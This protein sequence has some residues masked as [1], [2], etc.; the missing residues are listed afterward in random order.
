MGPKRG[1]ELS[2]VDPAEL[3]KIDLEKLDQAWLAQPRLMAVFGDE[4]AR[5]HAEMMGVDAELKRTLAEIKLLYRKH[6]PSGIKITESALQELVD[7]ESS[8]R[9]LR[10]QLV[11]CTERYERLRALVFA[12]ENRKSAL[13]NLVRLYNSEYFSMPVVKIEHE[14]QKH[15][16]RNKLAEESRHDSKKKG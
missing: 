4:M 14:I 10:E 13:E 6:P 1:V 15:R 5:A 3:V 12:L 2:K 11:K 16:V 7:S 9:R 8:V